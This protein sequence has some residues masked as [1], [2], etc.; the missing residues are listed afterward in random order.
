MSASTTSLSCPQACERRVLRVCLSQVMA[1]PSAEKG[2]A[3]L[4]ILSLPNSPPR[5]LW[6]R[7]ALCA[8]LLILWCAHGA[9][10][11]KLRA[12]GPKARRRLSIDEEPSGVD[13]F[14]QGECY[15]LAGP[16]KVPRQW[17]IKWPPIA[18]R[19]NRF[20]VRAPCAHQRRGIGKALG[21]ALPKTRRPQTQ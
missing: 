6:K 9:R 18:L 3:I 17:H 2:L 16:P 4:A 20:A 1:S 5:R 12:H 10:T 13:A 21:K 15:P 7:F 11:A 8:A 19:A 14:G